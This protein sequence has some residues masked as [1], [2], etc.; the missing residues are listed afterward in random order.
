MISKIATK[1]GLQETN[2]QV[3]CTEGSDEL[4][5]PV[6]WFAGIAVSVGEGF[7]EFVIRESLFT[8]PTKAGLEAAMA[9]GFFPLDQDPIIDGEGRRPIFRVHLG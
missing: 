1:M 8:Y 7:G 3:F 9:S 2:L 4:R 5:S 6:S